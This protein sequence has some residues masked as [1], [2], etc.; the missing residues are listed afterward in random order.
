M[1]P[2]TCNKHNTTSIEANPHRISHPVIYV[3]VMSDPIFHFNH[4]RAPISVMVRIL[5]FLF[6][7]YLLDP[8]KYKDLRNSISPQSSIQA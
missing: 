5:K 7:T 2:D 1:V 4:V 3:I 8:Q 6:F